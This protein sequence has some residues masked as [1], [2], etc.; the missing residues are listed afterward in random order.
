MMARNAR[1]AR[2]ANREVGPEAGTGDPGSASIGS[3]GSPQC[4][5]RTNR[6]IGPRVPPDDPALR[7]QDRDPASEIPDRIRSA[8]GPN[9]WAGSPRARGVLAHRGG[10]RRP[11]IAGRAAST[12]GGKSADPWLFALQSPAR[13]TS[14]TLRGKP[15]TGRGPRR[16]ADE[17]ARQPAASRPPSRIK[18]GIGLPWAGRSSPH[19]AA[20]GL[21]PGRGPGR[22]RTF[23]QARPRPARVLRGEGPAGPGGALHQLPRAGQAE[24]RAPARLARRR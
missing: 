17:P 15:P 16:R 22:R 20:P 24:G 19:R 4:R 14:G 7:P 11:R 18:G 3:H 23:G 2:G 6:R 9:G 21:D 5:P 13:M 8:G 12:I 1:L 10:R